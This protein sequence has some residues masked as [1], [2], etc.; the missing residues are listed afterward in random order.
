MRKVWVQEGKR[1]G[2]FLSVE[3]AADL[4]L[5]CSVAFS[6]LFGLIFSR[7]YQVEHDNRRLKHSI[8]FNPLATCF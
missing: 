2:S 5:V 3:F 1:E 6:L 7:E 4:T 8:Y